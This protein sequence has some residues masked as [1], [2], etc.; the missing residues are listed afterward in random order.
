VSS[1]PGGRRRSHRPQAGGSSPLDVAASAGSLIHQVSRE[2]STAL[3]REF[4]PM[5]LTTQQAAVLVRVAQ[6]LTSPSKLKATLG[7]D[8]AGMTRLLDRLEAK[9]LLTRGQ[10][11]QDRRAIV[12]ELT[13]QARALLPRLAPVFRGVNA[14]LS[15]GLDEQEVGQVTAT[16]QQML[17]NLRGA[18]PGAD[19]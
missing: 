17:A 6:G 18:A 14:R 3:D 11:P 4:A 7:T 19:G 16:L 2:L 5:E 13:E 9:G 8:N 12:I 10:H 1:N 15:Q